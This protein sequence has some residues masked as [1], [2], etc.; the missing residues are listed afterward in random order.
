[1]K[2]GGLLWETDSNYSDVKPVICVILLQHSQRTCCNPT[3]QQEGGGK[4][5][6]LSCLSAFPHISF[7]SLSFSALSQQCAI[8]IQPFNA[9]PF[10]LLRNDLWSSF[11]WVFGLQVFA[12]VAINIQMRTF[13]GLQ[14]LQYWKL[15]LV[16]TLNT[17]HILLFLGHPW[18]KNPVALVHNVLLSLLS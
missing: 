2:A 11:H 7:F 9:K 12:L 4:A 3:D 18:K 13:H 8:Y 15:S 1:M 17:Q 6:A 14:H 16:W 10:T 5:L